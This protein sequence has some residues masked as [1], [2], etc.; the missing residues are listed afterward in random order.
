M[1][2]QVEIVFG[3]GS[4]YMEQAFEGLDKMKEA[5]LILAAEGVKI[6]DTSAFY[7]D[8]EAILGKL[9]AAKT[10]SIESKYPGG[11]TPTPS[12]KEGI[13]A[14]AEESLK[15]LG[16]EKFDVYYLHSPDRRVPF[17]LQVEAMNT[18]YERGKI[19]RFGISNF[20]PNEVEEVIRISTEKNWIMPSVYQGGYSAVARRYETDLFPI[21]R[22]HNIQFYGYAPSAGG[23][24]AKSADKLQSNDQGRWDPSNVMGAMHHTLFNKPALLDGLRL[25]EKISEESGIPNIELAY[26]WVVHNSA[27]RKGDKIIF[28]ARSLQQLQETLASIKK[29]PLSAEIGK[30]IEEVWK[31]AE[32][33]SPRDNYNDGMLKV[34]A[35]AA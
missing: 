21:L 5:L 13:I 11:L 30:R 24:L 16:M 18:L 19:A 23:F 12:T 3:G 1:S 4:W 17:E 10:H 27:L 6:I 26:R 28:G 7:M 9:S 29:G 32:K 8:S 34:M 33:D 25:W 22:K 20:F 15:K 14:A 31:I 2:S 35:Q